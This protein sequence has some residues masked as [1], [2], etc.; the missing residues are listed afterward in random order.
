MND[1]PPVAGEA[2]R[3]EVRDMLRRTKRKRKPLRHPEFIYDLD[4]D[5]SVAD[6]FAFTAVK[7]SRRRTSFLAKMASIVIILLWMVTMSLENTT[8][9]V[10]S[11]SEKA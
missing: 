11:L 3:P 5:G 10:K 1:A 4:N 7:T 9:Q 2:D 6:E 8:P